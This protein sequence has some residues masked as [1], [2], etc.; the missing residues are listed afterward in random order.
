MSRKN[1]VIIHYNTPLLT[2]CLIDSINKFVSD[3]FIYIFDNS[4]KEPFT[5]K[6]DNVILLDNT[7]GQIID[8][9][10]WLEKYPNK[11]KSKEAT[12]CFGSAKHCYSVQK[13][14]D[15]IND[16]FILLDSDVL[17]KKDISK[18]INE[19]TIYAGETV[20]QPFTTIK[21][22]L[23]FICYI[24]TRICRKNGVDFFNDNYMHGLNNTVINKS[25]DNYDTG[26]Y[27]FMAASRFKHKDIKV[28][29]YIVHYKAGSWVENAKKRPSHTQTMTIEEWLNE[30]KEYWSDDN[31]AEKKVSFNK[32]VIYTCI[33]GDYDDLI[34][35]KYVTPDFDYICFTDNDKLTSDV[36]QIRKMP[37]RIANLSKVKQQRYVK[38]NAHKVLKEY[39]L[40]IWVDGSVTI[41]SDLNTFIDKYVNNKCSIYVPEHPSRNCIYK[42]ARAVIAMKKD[43]EENVNPQIDKYKAEEFPSNYGLLQSNIM[44][45][46][47]NDKKCIKLMECWFK[48]VENGSHRD[49]LSFNYACWKNED[50]DVKYMDKNICASEW[51]KW[52]TK[53]SNK[54][55]EQSRITLKD[56]SDKSA[57]IKKMIEEKRKAR[58]MKSN[59]NITTDISTIFG[60]YE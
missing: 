23:P 48:E 35:P 11:N 26:A 45:R 9:D 20:I 51:F 30:Y 39:D 53:H 54:S 2:E 14:M 28:D 33:T 31:D 44:V 29:D 13:C 15:I 16:G 36:W 37:K 46:K 34:E 49:Q 25:A 22:I 8:F 24:N 58:Q 7:K 18:L 32:K 12:H 42:E 6:Y 40:S 57:R 27:F 5:A 21:R 50:V 43:V 38:I 55:T 1:I 47:H 3:A 10:K 19:T 17:L 60:L 41:K 52:N 4:D 56:L 59:K